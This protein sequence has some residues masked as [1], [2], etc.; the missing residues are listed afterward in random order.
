MLMRQRDVP[1]NHDQPLSRALPLKKLGNV[2]V[3]T[4]A[5]RASCRRT[6]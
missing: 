3:A 6:T 2:L 4:G 5:E 1:I